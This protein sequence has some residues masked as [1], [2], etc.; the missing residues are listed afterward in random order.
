LYCHSG[1]LLVVKALWLCISLC[2]VSW[3]AMQ[4]MPQQQQ[5]QPFYGPLSMTIQV[6]QYQKK[7]PPTRTYHSHQPSFIS[8]LHLLWSTVSS[9][10]KLLAWHSLCTTFV[11]KIVKNCLIIYAN[12]VE[13]HCKS[14]FPSALLRHWASQRNFIGVQGEDW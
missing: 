11:Q 2:I 14:H 4:H 6:S 12:T 5:Q 1:T 10:F 8:F 3:Q 9:L 13:R 7:H